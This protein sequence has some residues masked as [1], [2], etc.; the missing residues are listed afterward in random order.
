MIESLFAAFV[1]VEF[2]LQVLPY[3]NDRVA[4][5]VGGE[6]LGPFVSL[7]ENA[8]RGDER[9]YEKVLFVCQIVILADALS[10][11]ADEARD[12]HEGEGSLH[13][14]QIQLQHSKHGP[15]ARPFPEEVVE[16]VNEKKLLKSCHALGSGPKRP[17]HTAVSVA[18]LAGDLAAV[19]SLLGNLRSASSPRR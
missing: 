10:R 14:S 12:V 11:S 18:V 13:K 15:D 1:E 9:K 7:E 6:F 2:R 3:G 17:D 4:E 19:S 8:Q 5:A 16:E